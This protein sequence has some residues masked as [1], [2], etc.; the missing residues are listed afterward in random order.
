MNAPT[1]IEVLRT[2]AGLASRELDQAQAE[3]SAFQDETAAKESELRWKV[4]AIVDR[5]NE[6]TDAYHRLGGDPGEFESKHENGSA[7]KFKIYFPKSA[8]DLG[9]GRALTARERALKRLKAAGKR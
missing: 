8:A 9:N 3:L 6:F 2:E 1:P 7:F 5:L 4:S